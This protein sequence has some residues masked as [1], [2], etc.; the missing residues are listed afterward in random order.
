MAKVEQK[1]ISPMVDMPAAISTMLASA[2]PILKNLS[3]NAF[4]NVAVMVDLD[5]SASRT[6]TLSL[7]LP[8]SARASP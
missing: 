8:S 2:M 3:G 6:T 1:G 4:W 7:T 5:R